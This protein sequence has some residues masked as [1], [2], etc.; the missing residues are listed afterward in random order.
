MSY[1]DE[2][3]KR[4]R[5]NDKNFKALSLNL[6][7]ME[8]D[9]SQQL[10]HWRESLFS[11]QVSQWIE[12]I[13]NNVTV[14]TVT[15]DI[16]ISE[17]TIWKK[18]QLRSLMEALGSLPRLQ[19]FVCRQNLV[20]QPRRTAPVDALV[21][22]I[23]NTVSLRHF[24]FWGNDISVEAH[25]CVEK[26][27][28]SLK[29]CIGLKT[30]K[31]RGFH[32]TMPYIVMFTALMEMPS[33]TDFALGNS[34]D[35]FLPVAKA[36]AKN[37]HLEHLSL[38][39]LNHI[40]DNV[41]F[42]LM[43][44]LQFNTKLDTLALLNTSPRNNDCGI[45]ERSHAA[46]IHMLEQNMNLSELKTRGSARPDIQFY[47]KLNK[48]GRRHLFYNHWVTRNDWVDTV[49]SARDDMDCTFYF[50]GMNPALCV[51]AL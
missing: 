35:G 9:F 14:D 1:L 39:F 44:A 47:L 50:I 33:V 28:E 31:I 42:A 17:E 23:R 24:E 16:S 5:E 40:D 4:L 21:H 32:L 19:K 3:L 11:F 41:C 29:E 51:D 18:D 34:S 15:I 46:L 36:V 22:A 43:D 12:V 2:Q 7:R 45:S 26:L 37:G 38:C 6:N 8:K 27:V 25:A 49:V 10:A 13:R 30:V 20:G 48:A